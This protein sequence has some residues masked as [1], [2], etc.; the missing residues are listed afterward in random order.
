LASLFC[1]VY[2]WQLRPE[3]TQGLALPASIR[4]SWNKHTSLRSDEEKKFYNVVTRTS[5][6]DEGLYQCVAKAEK[7]GT[8]VSRTAKLQ[9]AG[10]IT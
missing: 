8:I 2:Y 4:L 9:V 1:L 10:K 3:L 7:I 6:P 5:R